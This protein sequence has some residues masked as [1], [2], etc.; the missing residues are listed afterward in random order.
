M[1]G[2]H[3]LGRANFDTKSC[4]SLFAS[5]LL[6]NCSHCIMYMH[7]DLVIQWLEIIFCR[8]HDKIFVYG[9]RIAPFIMFFSA[10][11]TQKHMFLNSQYSLKN[12]VCPC[13][14]L[15]I[16]DAWV[17]FFHFLLKRKVF[18]LSKKMTN[19]YDYLLQD[20]T[21]I[22]LSNKLCSKE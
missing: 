18:H 4:S 17:F 2:H 3:I 9:S 10:N 6:V 12:Y 20:T 14:L 5:K 15:P 8:K 1:H 13:L 21:G 22:R 19:W 16:G 7:H 11:E